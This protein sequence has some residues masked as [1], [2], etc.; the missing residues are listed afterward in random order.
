MA[1]CMHPVFRNVCMN[2]VWKE[3]LLPCGIC[4]N[5]RKNFAHSW[6]VRV[7]HESL[8]Y[9]KCLFLTLTYDPSELPIGCKGRPTINISDIQNFIK[10]W[11][12]YI[13]PEKIRYFCGCEYSPLN[14]LPHYHIAVFGADLWDKRVFWNHYRHDDGYWVDCRFWKKGIVHVANLDIGSSC[15]VAGYALKKVMGSKN[16]NYYN[17]LG[18]VAPRALMSR[19]PGIGDAFL[20]Q[21]A[22]ELIRLGCVSV[23]GWKTALPRFY[24]NKSGFKDT[25]DY[26]QIIEDCS[27]K[28]KEDFL[29]YL[30]DKK[31]WFEKNQQYQWIDDYHGRLITRNKINE[32]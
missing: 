13:E 25:D 20:Q 7:Y 23:D 5:C 30:N 15:Y 19:R 24:I 14:K 26:K 6:G 4:G 32:I 1:S 27:K 29:S 12:E 17:D 16:K 28:A 21:H 22:Q 8:F 11:R 3:M 18:I 31:A 9:D 10:S 2:G